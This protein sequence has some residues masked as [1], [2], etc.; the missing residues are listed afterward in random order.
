MQGRT[1]HDIHC[2]SL[3]YKLKRARAFYCLLRTAVARVV[4]LLHG[5]RTA[6]SGVQEAMA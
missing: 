1:G 6:L 5:E 4:L 2:D 3:H